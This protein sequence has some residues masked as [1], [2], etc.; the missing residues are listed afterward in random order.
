MN[1]PLRMALG[2]VLLSTLAI[3]ATPVDAAENFA[4][5]MVSKLKLGEPIQGKVAILFPLVVPKAPGD[6]G[7][8]SQNTAEDLTF[9]EPEFPD[10]RYAV[11]V[12]NPTDKPV[13][14]LGGTVLVG[15]KRD[16]MLRHDTI[17]GAGKTVQVRALPAAS[18]SDIRKEPV[19]FVLGKQLAPVYLRRKADFGGSS[20]TVTTF[21]ARNLDFRNEG[22]QRKSLA[23]LGSSDVLQKYTAEGRTKLDAALKGMK[24]PNGEI[25]GWILALRGRLQS[26]VVFG[27]R[28][29]AEGYRGAFLL[30]ATYSAAAIEI[31]AAKKNVPMPGKD[32]PAKTLAIVTKEAQQ[33]LERIQKARYK[34]DGSQPEGAAGHRLLMQLSGGARG[35]VVGA[36][37]KLVHMAVYPHDPFANAF[38][39]SKIDLE[40]PDLQS[41]PTR[42]GLAELGRKAKDGRRLSESERRLLRRVGG[43]RTGGGVPGGRRR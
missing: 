38:Y 40:N 30:G 5:A 3:S 26:F 4:E 13:L 33:L 18:S 8:V 22:D 20:T 9:A 16:R 41:D 39:G 17:V 28:Q 1:T 14:L 43:G 11:E 32:D 23:A 12:T 6:A 35:R 19:P 25:V 31:Q 36:N 34:A 15:G 10:H 24:R 42:E 37:D 29:V 7:V 21:I 27:D 2:I